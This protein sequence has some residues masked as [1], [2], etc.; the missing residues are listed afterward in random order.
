MMTSKRIYAYDSTKVL[1]FKI[2]AYILSDAISSR[3]AFYGLCPGASLFLFSPITYSMQMYTRDF[4]AA[5][6]IIGRHF[7]ISKERASI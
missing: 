6:E 5:S 7:E 1:A 4:P 3:V 2:V